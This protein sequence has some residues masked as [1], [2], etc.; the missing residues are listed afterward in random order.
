[1]ASKHAAEQKKIMTGVSAPGSFAGQANPSTRANLLL[2]LP[3]H[4]ISS[5]GGRPRLVTY[6]FASVSLIETLHWMAGLRIQAFGA[7]RL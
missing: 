1:V 2:Q 5:C 6:R 4:S 7:S 3:A